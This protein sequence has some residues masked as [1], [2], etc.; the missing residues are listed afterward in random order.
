MPIAGGGVSYSAAAMRKKPCDKRSSPH[1]REGGKGRNPFFW[2]PHQ[3]EGSCSPKAKKGA[4]RASVR[5]SFIIT[6]GKGTQECFYC[7]RMGKEEKAERGAK[8]VAL[9]E[10][11]GLLVAR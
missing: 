10:G 1:V 11:K 6:G 8:E 5:R 4:V 3:K 9:W 2:G 7:G